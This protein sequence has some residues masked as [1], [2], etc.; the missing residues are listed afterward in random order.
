LEKTEQVAEQR[1]DAKLAARA[2]E[3]LGRLMT[4]KGLMDDAA[5]FYRLLARD[6]AEV[7]VRDGKTGAEVLAD[8]SADKRFWPY[9]DEMIA[10]LSGSTVNVMEIPSGSHLISPVA[11]FEA[12]TD[13]LPFFRRYALA[14][15]LVNFNGINSFQLRLLDKDN[16]ESLWSLTAPASRAS[17]MPYGAGLQRFPF[18]TKG[19]LVVLYLGHTVYAIDL[20]ERKKL[21]DKDLISPERFAGEPPYQQHMLSLDRH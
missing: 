6:F 3:L 15:S 20:I 11:P 8:L 7:A 14:G 17:Y 18:Y 1:D 5:Y 4:R 13:L 10:P 19:H 16:N 2:V 12:K 9:L 21:W